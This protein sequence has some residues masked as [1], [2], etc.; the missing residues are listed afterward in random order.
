ML[1]LLMSSAFAA[2]SF[3]VTQNWNVYN[4]NGAVQ[5]GEWA[6]FSEDSKGVTTSDNGYDA[7]FNMIVNGQSIGSAGVWWFQIELRFKTISRICSPN[8]MCWVDGVLEQWSGNQFHLN[9]VVRNQWLSQYINTDH[10][11]GA[12]QLS[13]FVFIQVTLVSATNL[14]VQV[15]IK[16]QDT[17]DTYLSKSWNLAASGEPISSIQ[18][19]EGI[20]V[21]NP[22]LGGSAC[23]VN[24]NGATGATEFGDHY[25][26]YLDIWTTT[27]IAMKCGSAGS[28]SAETS[29][30]VETP[31][32]PTNCITEPY[33]GGYLA[34]AQ[35]TQ[36]IGTGCPCE[37]PT[38]PSG[39]ESNST[40]VPT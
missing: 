23:N 5:Y 25:T 29:N 32:Q 9:S 16:N 21:C 37:N 15:V 11:E 36:T 17:G 10:T 3:A 30:L 22:Y 14:Q 39:P 24:F 34:N 19:A 28:I 13:V 4:G 8:V 38:P 18:Q 7:Q 20:A 27:N 1:I 35:F 33:S 40:D 26:P 31:A 6:R 12:N 2:T